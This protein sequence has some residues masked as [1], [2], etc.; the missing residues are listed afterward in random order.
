ML[1][2]ARVAAACGA[3]VL[4]HAGCDPGGEDPADTTAGS[5]NSAGTA[6]DGDE[7]SGTAA[8]EESGAESGSGGFVDVDMNLECG[9]PCDPVSA[10]GCD[11]GEKCVFRECMGADVGVC[12]PHGSDSTGANC[13]NE[14]DYDSCDFDSLC[15]PD[16]AGNAICHARCDGTSCPAGQFCAAESYFPVC[17]VLCDPFGPNTCTQPELCLGETETGF[18][19]FQSEAQGAEGDPCKLGW[20]CGPGLL[21]VEDAQCADPTQPC[22]ASICDTNLPTCPGEAACVSQELQEQP[23]LDLGYCDP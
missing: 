12:V 3:L 11:A 6:T 23:S 8:S 4:L 1:L 14:P 16:W 9:T 10:G 5:G 13:T 22:C 21:C 20:G 2:R 15:L 18:F 17:L 7:A 19:C